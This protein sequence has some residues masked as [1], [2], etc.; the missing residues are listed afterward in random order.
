MNLIFNRFSRTEPTHRLNESSCLILLQ[1]KK[2]GAQDPLS[3]L[4]RPERPA[5]RLL[6]LVRA[7]AIA[8]QR[9]DRC[10]KEA[11]IAIAI[12]LRLCSVLQLRAS[13]KR[14][15][16]PSCRIWCVFP[17]S[18]GATTRRLSRSAWPHNKR[19][20]L[21]LPHRRSIAGSHCSVGYLPVE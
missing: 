17:R 4:W 7:C 3:L 16:P 5:S 20:E 9:L 8:R 11:R 21:T 1:A 2:K 10:Q 12:L 6:G 13:A 14:R 19:I 18:M 15:W